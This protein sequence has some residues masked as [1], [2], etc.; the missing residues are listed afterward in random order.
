MIII[1]TIIHNNTNNNKH[2]SEAL[3]C[4]GGPNGIA[5]ATRDLYLEM[6]YTLHSRYWAAIV[7]ATCDVYL[8]MVLHTVLAFMRSERDDTCTVN[9][10]YGTFN[11]CMLDATTS[12]ITDSEVLTVRIRCVLSHGR[13]VRLPSWASKHSRLSIFRGVLKPM[14]ISISKMLERICPAKIRQIC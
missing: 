11:T 14:P 9:A 13:T 3:L 5:R 2:L 7:H 8:E 1:A 6:R 12:H 10:Q 4:Q